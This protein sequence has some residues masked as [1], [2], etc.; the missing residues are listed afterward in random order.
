MDKKSIF[1][2][3]LIKLSAACFISFSFVL[4]LFIQDKFDLYKISDFLSG[5][6][7]NLWFYVLFC[8]AILCSF[9]IDKLSLIQTSIT[10]KVLLYIICGYLFFLPVQLFSDEP[11]IFFFITGSIGAICAVFFYFCTYIAQNSQWFRYSIPILIPILFIT[12]ASTDFTKK[13]Q[14]VEHTTK[15]EFEVTFSYFNGEHKIPI[16]VKKGET[17]K[18]TLYFPTTGGYGF[19][20]SSEFNKVEPMSEISEDTYQLSATQTGTYYIVVT[21]DDLKGEIKANWNIQ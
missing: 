17:L 8:Y 6:L 21:G 16:H 3:L 4:F 13:E 19:H 14:W 7:Y 10:K 11:C 12:I 20:M 9:I 2:Y 1:S 18:F 5:L 15:N